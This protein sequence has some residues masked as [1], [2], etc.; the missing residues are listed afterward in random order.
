MN[1]NLNVAFD[2]MKNYFKNNSKF[3]CAVNEYCSDAKELLSLKNNN[4]NKF[5]ELKT[6]IL[7]FVFKYV[8]ENNDI[9]FINLEIEYLQKQREAEHIRLKLLYGLHETGRI[10]LN[11]YMN[12]WNTLYILIL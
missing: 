1:K 11:K 6:E 2:N 8:Q 7:L 4:I 10:F 9:T 12:S 3:M 5:V